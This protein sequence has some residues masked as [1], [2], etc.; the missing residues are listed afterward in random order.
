MLIR[1]IFLLGGLTTIAVAAPSITSVANAASGI[2]QALPNGGI[3][4]GSIFIVYGSGLGPAT[5]LQVQS[6]PLPTSQGLGGTTV[7]VSVGGSQTYCIMIYTLESQVAAILPSSTPAGTGTLTVSY[8]GAQ[9][10]IA[11]QVVT[12]TFGTFAINENGSGPGVFTDTS[13]AVKDVLNPAHVGDVLILWGT[14]LGPITGDETQPPQ[15]VDLGTGVQVFVG[16]QAATVLYGGRASSSGEDQ[17]DFTVPDTIT[18]CFVPVAVKVGGT[19]SNI[20]TLPIALKGETVCSDPMEALTSDDLNAFTNRGANATLNIAD[21][22]LNRFYASSDKAKANFRQY[23]FRGLISLYVLSGAPSIGG[24]AEYE[25]TGAKPNVPDPVPFQPLDAGPQVSVNGPNGSQ[26]LTEDSTGGYSATLGG[27][28]SGQPAYLSPGN[29]TISDGSGGKAV[30]AFSAAL[31]V[32][33]SITWT[34]PPTVVNRSQDLTVS[35]SGASGSSLVAIVGL[36][37]V[38]ISAST[39]AFAEIICAADPD[40]GQFV[41]PSFV[42]ST[43]P[44]NGI[45]S[46]TAAG[47]ILEVAGVPV[48]RFTASGID[49]GLFYSVIGP[50]TVASIQ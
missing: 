8:Q 33:Q 40:A 10:S 18:G 3:A 2:P 38:P 46:A 41:I 42:L 15:Q 17:I 37:A 14:G 25:Y 7:Q 29:Y 30:G 11:I 44:A 36:T 9:A 26:T 34:N 5:L 23:D 50:G 16:S 45:V 43:L 24:C 28:N 32:P 1:G 35:W 21:I 48:T 4:R 39:S 12:N 47:V 49:V 31:T 20:T 22:S 19:V 13:Y 6:Y 27:G